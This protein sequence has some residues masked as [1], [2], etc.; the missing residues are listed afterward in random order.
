MIR[1]EVEKS[2][3]DRKACSPAGAGHKLSDL[4]P[5]FHESC[6][7]WEHRGLLLVTWSVDSIPESTLPRPSIALIGQI[8]H[9]ISPWYS[10]LSPFT[11]FLSRVNSAISAILKVTS[12]KICM[13]IYFRAGRLSCK[14]IPG[15]PW[16]AFQLKKKK[17]NAEK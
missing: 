11:A 8:N 5:L 3:P 10:F 1:I 14:F 13:Q 9:I 4:G 7:G 12:H 2:D 6:L 16:Q 17:D 15:Q